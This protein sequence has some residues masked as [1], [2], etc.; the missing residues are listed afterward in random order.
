ML[1]DRNIEP[2]CAYCRYSTALGRNEYACVKN[3]V[4]GGD[5]FCGAFRYEPIKRVP[6]VLPSVYQAILSDEDFRL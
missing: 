5:G 3:G 1:F 4:M 6:P 2:S